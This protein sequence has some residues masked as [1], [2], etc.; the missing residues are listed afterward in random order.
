MLNPALMGII[1][2]NIRQD[3]HDAVGM[4]V[5]ELN[6]VLQH[7][8]LYAELLADNHPYWAPPEA[9]EAGLAIDQKVLDT[10]AGYLLYF[11]HGESFGGRGGMAPQI[12]NGVVWLTLSHGLLSGRTDYDGVGLDVIEVEDAP[13]S[14][15]AFQVTVESVLESLE[16]SSMYGEIEDAGAQVAIRPGDKNPRC[17]NITSDD[18]SFA[19]GLLLFA[20]STNPFC[21]TDKRLVEGCATILDSGSRNDAVE[22]S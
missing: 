14:D 5:G 19:I 20:L 17:W 4:L 2:R 6:R 10:A 22:V 3:V 15:I 13:L 8:T 12:S 21:S 16:S 7:G 11:M 1:D 9:V 18:F